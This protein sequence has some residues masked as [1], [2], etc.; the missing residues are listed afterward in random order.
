MLLLKSSDGELFIVEEAVAMQS[1]SIRHMIETGR[2]EN[3]AVIPIHGVDAAILSE[4]LSYCS[5]HA[6]VSP[7]SAEDLKNFDRDLVDANYATLLD[8][9]FVRFL[10]TTLI[11][12]FF[13]FTFRF[14]FAIFSSLSCCVFHFLKYINFRLSVYSN[15]VGIHTGSTLYGR[16]RVDGVGVPSGGRCNRGA[17]F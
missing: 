5:K 15:C 9:I 8:L 14:S 17:V 7:T 4:V 6:K 12:N 13:L 3:G 11:F 2:A 10:F 16:K 1:Q